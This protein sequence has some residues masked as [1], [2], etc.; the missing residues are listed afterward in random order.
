MVAYKKLTKDERQGI[1]RRMET[2]RRR[3]EIDDRV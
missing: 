2:L 3:K 1:S